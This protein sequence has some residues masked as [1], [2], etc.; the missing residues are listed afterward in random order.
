MATTAHRRYA[1]I[2][3]DVEELINDHI[4]QQKR[5]TQAKSK[6]KLLVPSVG[7]FFT[8]LKLEDA[9]KFQD[10]RRRISSRR[11]VPPSF[12]DIRLTLNSAQMMSL[13]SS[14]PVQLMTF[15]G[16]V[17]LYNDGESLTDENPVISR[18]L[19][20]LRQGI[21]V[22]IVTA[23]GYTNATRYYERLHGL[24]D[25]VSKA[26]TDKEIE[27]PKVIILGGESNYLFEFDYNSVS[28]LNFV[29]R[30][31]W[32]LDEMRKWQEEDIQSLLDVAEGALKECINR[33]QLS[34]EMIRK[35]RAVGIIPC[36]GPGKHKFTREQLEETV[37]V[38]QQIL[39]LSDP[40]KK[41]PFCAFNGQ[42]ARSTCHPYRRFPHTNG[43]FDLGGNDVFVDIGDKSW[44]VLS[45]QRYLGGIDGNKTLH[46]GDQ[47]LSAGANDFKARLAC[48]TAWI[49]SPAETV[50]LLDEFHFHCSSQGKQ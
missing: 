11:F 18:I 13:A 2:M 7:A 41:V 21:C 23:A 38:T 4:S 50:A 34:A 27:D 39:E 28:F 8:P 1:E 31:V 44:G 26:V 5:G 6:L 10:G 17:T 30:D 15:D 19:R 49:A 9:F 42:Q 29:P 24:L 14:G 22:G 35:D 33:M 3:R 40:G 48:T 37:L 32:L 47:F 25:A 12:N 16:D 43:L 36:P 20:L 45:C 46:V